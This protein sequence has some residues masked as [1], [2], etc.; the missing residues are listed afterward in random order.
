[1]LE[2][3]KHSHDSTTVPHYNELLDFIDVCA[4]AS[5]LLP[6]SKKPN[7]ASKPIASFAAEAS[8]VSPKCLLCKTNRHPL[9]VCSSFKLL[10][11]DQKISIVKSNGICMNCL[12]PGHFVKQCKS[13][14]HCKTCQKPHHT[15]LHIDNTPTS[16]SL[17]STQSKPNVGV[18]LISSNAAT[19]LLRNLLM[20]TCVVLVGG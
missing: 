13:L 15:L 6:S 1:M 20:M 17:T 14:H 11:H 10:P 9:Y 4:Q 3:Q 16:S 2:W 7:H 5:E 19:N 12:K 18:P 8:N